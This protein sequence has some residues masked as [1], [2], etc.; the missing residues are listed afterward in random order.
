MDRIISYRPDT[1]SNWASN[2]IVLSQGEGG[3]ETDTGNVKIGD[4]STAWNDLGYYIPAKLAIPYD[5]TSANKTHTLPPIT[6]APQ[7]ESVYWTGG[8]TYKL[9]IKR[10]DGT[11]LDYKGEGNGH[12][13]VESD[14]SNWQVREYKD[15]R[16]ISNNRYWVKYLDKRI[17]VFIW[18]TAGGDDTDS[19][20]KD[21]TAI[22]SNTPII[23]YN[24]CSCSPLGAS[25]SNTTTIT[26]YT[27][28]P[29]KT[30]CNA[31]ISTSGVVHV[32]LDKA[33]GSTFVSG[34]YYSF[35][36]KINGNWG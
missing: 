25:S 27:L 19:I 6:G 9:T 5:L 16:K 11:Y 17:D 2:N 18:T 33:D 8:G 24:S 20:G 15:S 32:R 28:S 34:K 23:S 1:A 31:I 3:I 22:N 13:L 30:M 4:G 36:V 14:G 12:I 35:S 7:T 10:D 21:L 26:D 29:S